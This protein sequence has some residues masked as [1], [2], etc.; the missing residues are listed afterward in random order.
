MAKRKVNIGGQILDAEEI[1]FQ[2][3]SE[4][5]GEQWSHYTL[6]DGTSL[7]VKAVLMNVL[8][9][10]N[11]YAPNGDPLYSVNSSIVVASSSPESLRKKE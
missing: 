3:D 6:L 5:G 4:N 9:I 11:A 1:S 7:R 2:P 8:R 10:D